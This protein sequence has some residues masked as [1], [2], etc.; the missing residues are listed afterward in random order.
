MVRPNAR[1]SVVDIA[2]KTRRPHANVY[3]VNLALTF[4]RPNREPIGQ[5]IMRSAFFPEDRA[6]S[7]AQ[8]SVTVALG[9]IWVPQFWPQ[10]L[11]LRSVIPPV[12]VAAACYFL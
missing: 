2:R 3:Q 10:E 7:A 5:D 11:E 4:S 8:L 12:V 1:R 6:F 9:A